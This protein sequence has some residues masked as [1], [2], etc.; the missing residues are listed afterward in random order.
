[1][2]IT[3]NPNACSDK[4]SSGNS[5][6]RVRSIEL[7]SLHEDDRNAMRESL[8]RFLAAEAD[9]AALRRGM[10]LDR[11]YD[12]E[13]WRQVCEMGLTG[14]AVPEDFGGVGGGARDV[15]M[16]CSEL[17]RTLVPLPFLDSCVISTSLLTA[18]A[19]NGELK[20]V[21]DHVVSG[22]SIVAVGGD[23]PFV[24]LRDC[25]HELVFHDNQT[26]SGTVSLVLNAAVADFVLL[27]VNVGERIKVVLV[28]AAENVVR[29]PQKANDPLLRPNTVRFENAAAIELEQLTASDIEKARMRG[30]AA[31]AALQAGAARAIFEIT[32]EYLKTR[33]Q[34][35]RPIGSF[36]ALKHMAADL[37]IEVES[38]ISAAQA[39]A[40]SID[41][42]SLEAGRTTALAGFVCTD[43]FREVAAQAIQMH[44]GIAYT[45]EH[46]AHLYWRRSR[47]MLAMLGS[48]EEHREDYLKAWEKAA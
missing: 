26:V 36:Q 47:A 33:Y 2:Y 28:P 18:C 20:Q 25:H 5:S 10:E 27:G 17:G 24:P 44:G 23:A 13:L 34:F 12:P 39:A 16:V 6:V 35:G 9:E 37:L 45:Q 31:L 46:V 38:A 1:M 30:V 22:T 8:S 4:C 41:A 42:G 3:Q 14:I 48:A 19:S 11:G 43:V 7:N 29:A 21:T 15:E 40:E 32:I